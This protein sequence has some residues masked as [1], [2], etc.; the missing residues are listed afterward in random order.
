MDV[1]FS[2]NFHD[3]WFPF[4][5]FGAFKRKKKNLTKANERQMGRV[6]QCSIEGEKKEREKKKQGVEGKAVS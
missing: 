3:F 2:L 5:Q 1:A 6:F 4:L